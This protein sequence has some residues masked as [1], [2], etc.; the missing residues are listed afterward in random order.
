[1]LSVFFFFGFWG[2]FFFF[3]FFFLL[4][5]IP[6]RAPELL[7]GKADY[8]ASIDLWSIGCI[9]AELLQNAPFLCGKSEVDQL[10]HVSTTN[11]V[12]LMVLLLTL[13]LDPPVCGQ[14]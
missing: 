5:S 11:L 7:L 1:M 8:T 2:F 4:T 14:P 10:N 6:F 3:F 12:Y 9:F 13:Q